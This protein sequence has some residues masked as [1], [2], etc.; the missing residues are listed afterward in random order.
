KQVPD[1]AD[2][3][4]DPATRTLVRAGVPLVTNPFD[5]PAI[6]L[7]VDL[8][9]RFGARA[10]VVTMGPPQAKEALYEALACGVDRAGH[11]CDDAFAGA[12]TLATARALAAF[13]RR[14]GFDVILCGK[15]T[16]DGETA[17]VGPELAELL[18]VPHV[19]GAGKITWGEGGASLVAERE[20]D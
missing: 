6:A 5:R 11:R 17:Q 14:E 16:V 7:A 13:A 18:D 15:H 10:T 20:A 2:L 4:F 12:D 3:R 9:Q 19:A 8:K 1:V